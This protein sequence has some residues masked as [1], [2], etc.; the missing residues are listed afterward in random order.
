VFLGGDTLRTLPG[1]SLLG[2]VDLALGPHLVV[3]RAPGFKDVTREISIS[4]NSMLE[5]SYELARRRSR[6]WYTLVATGTVGVVGGVIALLAGG[7]K[8]TVAAEP[9]PGPPPPPNP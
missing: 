7:G 9:L 4:P 6:T 2:D 3:V 1:D 5:Q 8:G